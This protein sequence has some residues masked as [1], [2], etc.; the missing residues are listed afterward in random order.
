MSRPVALLAR[1]NEIDLAVDATKARMYEIVEAMREPPVL[2]AARQAVAAAERELARSREVLQEREEAQAEAAAKAKR[3]EQKLYDGTIK[4]PR[5]VEDAQQDHA[6]L[7]NQLKAADEQLLEA[8]VVQESALAAHGRAQ[9]ELKQLLAERAARQAALRAEYATLKAR[10]PA[11]QARQAAARGA[12][13]GKALATYDILRQR[14]A[15]RAVA[16]LEGD[17]CS[18][19][20]VAV[21]PSKLAEVLDSEGLVYC[22]NCGRLLWSE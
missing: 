1:L 18:A 5:E 14:K 11:E 15:G 8:L 7:V 3:A 20:R 12:V 10:L 4:N 9:A 17:S 22:G 13:P 19:C 21:P 16:A 2:V 6:Q